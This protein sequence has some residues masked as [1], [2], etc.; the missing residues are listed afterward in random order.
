M[1]KLI[2]MLITIGMVAVAIAQAATHSVTLFWTDTVNPTGT[3]YNVYKQSG[4]CPT[5]PPTIGNIGSFVKLNA[6]AL[7]VL[8]YQD[9]TVVAGSGY[10]YYATAVNAGSESA[11]STTIYSGIVPT[12]FPPTG[13][14]LV[15]Q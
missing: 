6:T 8:T 5:T 2:L 1:K 9:S 15:I 12:A 4:V 10:C 11:P 7:T 14:I 3:T 13:I